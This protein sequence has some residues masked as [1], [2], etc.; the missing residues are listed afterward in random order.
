MVHCQAPIIALLRAAVALL[1]LRI[2]QGRSARPHYERIQLSRQVVLDI[3]SQAALS[4][5]LNRLTAR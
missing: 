3:D 4:A 1:V 5:P 2:L